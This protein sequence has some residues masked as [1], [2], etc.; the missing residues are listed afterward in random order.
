MI[1]K[2]AYNDRL[3]IGKHKT[4]PSNIVIIEVYFLTIEADNNEIEEIYARLEELCKLAKESDKLI[5]IGD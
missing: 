5:I 4:K 2:I 3:I 1:N